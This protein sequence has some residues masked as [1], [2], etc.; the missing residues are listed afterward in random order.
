MTTTGA[1]ILVICFLGPVM[2]PL[3]GLLFGTIF[4]VFRRKREGLDVQARG[5]LS[6]K[7]QLEL[8]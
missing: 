7:A 3:I 2:P 8:E 4:D 1:V 6:A 5:R